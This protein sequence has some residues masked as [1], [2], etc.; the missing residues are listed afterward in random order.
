MRNVST[1]ITFDFHL[2]QLISPELLQVRSNT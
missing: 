2:H 1:I